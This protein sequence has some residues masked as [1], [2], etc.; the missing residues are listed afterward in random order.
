MVGIE[1][2]DEATSNDT[3]ILENK[4]IVPSR[5]QKVDDYGINEKSQMGN[6]HMKVEK[7]KGGT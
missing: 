1:I 5:S 3:M 2:Q 4:T 7:D 6:F